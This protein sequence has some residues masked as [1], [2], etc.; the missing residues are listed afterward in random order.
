MAAIRVNFSGQIVCANSY[1][2]RMAKVAVEKMP[3]SARIL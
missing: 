2:G 3:T 1:G